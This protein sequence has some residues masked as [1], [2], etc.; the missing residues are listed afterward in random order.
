MRGWLRGGFLILLAALLAACGGAGPGD[1]EPL[2]RQATVLA[3][4][5]SVTHGT[6]AG[7]GEDYPARLAAI[8]GWTLINDGVPGDRANSA[9]GRLEPS[10]REHQP[11]LVL[12]WLGGNDFLRQRDPAAVKEDLRALVAAV[13]EHGAQP[14]LLGVPRASALGA[15]TGRL[16]DDPIYRELARE[17]QVALIEGVL[18]G[19]LSERDLRADPVHPNA[20]GYRRIAD[21]IAEALDDLGLWLAP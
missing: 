10:L 8:T 16:R 4:G 5:D 12:I 14:L 17:E 7:S 19:V 18:S 6:G 2:P 11:D 3:F 13:H 9:R 1:F 21:E 20:R 15:A